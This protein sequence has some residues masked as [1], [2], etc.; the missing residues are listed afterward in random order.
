M[1]D[2]EI[3]E[4]EIMEISAI[5]DDTIKF[6][7]IVSWCAAHPDEVAYALHLLLGRHGKRSAG[8]A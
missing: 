1:R 3:I 4:A 5:A 7:R 6:E 2:P 8:E